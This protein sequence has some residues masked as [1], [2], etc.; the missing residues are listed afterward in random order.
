MTLYEYLNDTLTRNEG[1]LFVETVTQREL[2]ALSKLL[3][4]L[5]E[6]RDAV[7]LASEPNSEKP[8]SCISA[9]AL[10]DQLNEPVDRPAAITMKSRFSREVKAQ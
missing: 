3:E 4:M 5:P 9:L 6:L 1:R 10:L 8:Y 7:H 2:N